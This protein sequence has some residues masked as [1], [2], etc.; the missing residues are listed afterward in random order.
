MFYILVNV[1]ALVL[2]MQILIQK[3]M[4]IFFTS[5]VRNC[6]YIPYGI[7]RILLGIAFT[8]S[9]CLTAFYTLPTSRRRLVGITKSRSDAILPANQLFGMNWMPLGV[10]QHQS[11][12]VDRTMCNMLFQAFNRSKWGFKCAFIPRRKSSESPVFRISTRS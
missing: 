7:C 4:Q 8:N 11:Q 3:I 12:D 10:Q 1:K 9:T 5:L 6:C 2:N